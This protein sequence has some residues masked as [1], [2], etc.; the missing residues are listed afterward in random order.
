MLHGITVIFLNI[1]R[2]ILERSRSIRNQ[3]SALYTE[4]KKV[5][6]FLFWA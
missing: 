2:S 5:F 4:M 1:T 6:F 3:P